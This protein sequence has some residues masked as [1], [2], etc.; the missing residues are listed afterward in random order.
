MSKKIVLV[1]TMKPHHGGK[2]QYTLSFIQAL[3][4]KNIIVLSS[5]NEWKGLL[6][7]K[8]M[9]HE[10]KKDSFFLK[11]FKQFL[12]LTS[13]GLIIIRKYLIF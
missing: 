8:F 6:P 9:F 1:L 10:L 12:R 3:S 5:I 4:E 11:L 2:Y 7:K 13:L